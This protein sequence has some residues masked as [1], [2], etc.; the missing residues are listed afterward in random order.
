M[1]IFTLGKIA[2]AAQKG[3]KC[4]ASTGNPPSQFMWPHAVDYNRGD[5]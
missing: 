5:H 2:A 1:E 3:K 4:E